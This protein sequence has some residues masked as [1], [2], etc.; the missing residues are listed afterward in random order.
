MNNRGFVTSA[1]LYGI[2]SLFLVLIL[3][4]LSVISNR[5]LASD[6]LKESAL[7]DA[8]NLKT[9]ESCFSFDRYCKIVGYNSD[10]CGKVVIID[11]NNISCV[12][13]GINDNSF[14]GISDGYVYIKSNVDISDNAF[15]GNNNVT[16]V[17]IGFNPSVSTEDGNIWGASNS[18]LKSY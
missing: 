5:K 17:T 13:K 2:L 15:S 8:E 3:G 12:L 7:I 4:T 18:H 1:L 9:E 10:E 14:N 16:F 6:R 11:Q